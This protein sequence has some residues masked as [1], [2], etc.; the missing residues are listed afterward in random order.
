MHQPTC[1]L[2]LPTHHMHHAV[3]LFEGSFWRL[4]KLCLDQGCGW[5]T[6]RC[7]QSITW[8]CRVSCETCSWLAISMLLVGLALHWHRHLHGHVRAWAHGHEVAKCLVLF[9]LVTWNLVRHRLLLLLC[10]IAWHKL[11]HILG[12]RVA[13]VLLLGLL[14]PLGCSVNLISVVHLLNLRPTARHG[15][16]LLDL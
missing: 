13:V 3:H 15:L 14:L 5:F 16:K 7:S 12:I 10:V 11:L 4:W 1:K 9:F 8:D 2:C 6:R